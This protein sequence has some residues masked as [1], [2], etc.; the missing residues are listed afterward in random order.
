[1]MKA[2]MIVLI[3]ALFSVT[4]CTE[5][6][7]EGA[8]AGGAIGGITGAL[9]DHRNPWRGGLIGAGLGAVAG[10]TIADISYR[11]SREVYTSGRPVEYRTE[12]GR[13]R[14]YAEPMDYDQR[15]R[16]RRVRERVWEDDRLVKDQEREVCE[17]RYD[18]YDRY[19]RRY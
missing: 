10:A 16:C 5:Y 9:L 4:A 7:G 14:Y 6:H 8:L 11:G 15:T 1:M 17:S 12:D 18:R 19:D 2:V 13:G 3:L